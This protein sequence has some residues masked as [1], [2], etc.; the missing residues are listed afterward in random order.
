M[1]QQLQ[2][3]LLAA[4]KRVSGKVE[5]FLRAKLDGFRE[6]TSLVMQQQAL[7]HRCSFAFRFLRQ[8]NQQAAEG[9]VGDYIDS[10]AKTYLKLVKKLSAST[11][12]E[13]KLAK[14]ELVVPKEAFDAKKGVESDGKKLLKKVTNITQRDRVHIPCEQRKAV[15]SA[16]VPDGDTLVVDPSVMVA[17]R[18][19]CVEDFVRVNAVMINAAVHEACF[20]SEFFAY[21][22]ARRDTMTS[23][24][25]E[26]AFAYVQERT[27]EALS[28]ASDDHISIVLLL[29]VCECMFS[30]LLPNRADKF[31]SDPN[32]LKST[33][34]TS[35]ASTTRGT[36]GEGVAQRSQNRAYRS[37]NF[38]T[39]HLK[40][41]QAR[42]WGAYSSTVGAHVASVRDAA[43]IAFAPA[44]LGNARSVEDC[45]RSYG[46]QLGVHGVV[47]RYMEL[48]CDLHTLNT[49][50]MVGSRVTGSSEGSAIFSDAIVADLATLRKELLR[51]VEGLAN[52]YAA[53]QL[54]PLVFT[55][56]NL[57]AVIQSFAEARV[58]S[59]YSEDPDAVDSFLR[60]RVAEFAE[61]EMRNEMSQLC[62]LVRSAVVMDA[63]DEQGFAKNRSAVD[64]N[65]VASVVNW[66]HGQWPQLLARA[67]GRVG[68]CFTNQFTAQYVLRC[69][70]AK[71]IEYNEQLRALVFKL[72]SE[73][74]CRTKLVSKE[75]I[76]HE[77]TSK[78]MP[79]F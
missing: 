1:Q 10:T 47:K 39:G 21:P 12:P 61:Q 59:S 30:H 37:P 72:W 46:P 45:I 63:S 76:V 7:A 60:E 26:K 55:A 23:S 25:F 15:L 74:P 40:D 22:S 29:R 18:R 6:G 67:A 64:G 9:I 24:V 16:L 28:A 20:M 77:V 49:T 68:V 14:Q 4:A 17:Q 34:V 65:E 58:S 8:Y 31:H 13:V 71:L 36:T 32:A 11:Q 66:F 33:L 73:P 70:F 79:S 56:N 3:K 19:T 41:V 52:R 57:S 50:P 27:N 75:V 35:R 5:K 2:P 54:T 38:L 42:L 69:V 48:A 78:Y 53:V 62:T 44:K 51:L 43:D